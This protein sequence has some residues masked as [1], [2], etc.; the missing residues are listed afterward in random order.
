MHHDTT[1]RRAER[2]AELRAS[3][4]RS[5]AAEPDVFERAA[6]IR[7]AVEVFR[8]WHGDA[9]DAAAFTLRCIVPSRPAVRR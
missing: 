7:C 5:I 8:K 9:F 1:S 3:V 4:A 2:S 6:R